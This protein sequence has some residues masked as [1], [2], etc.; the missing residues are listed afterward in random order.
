MIKVLFGRLYHIPPYLINI[1][2]ESIRLASEQTTASA[3][4]FSLSL[5]HVGS[6]Q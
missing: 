1:E 5:R 3:A 6:G 2:G 4:S